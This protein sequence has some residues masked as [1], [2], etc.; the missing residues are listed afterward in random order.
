MDTKLFWQLLEDVCQLGEFIAAI[1]IKGASID[2][3]GTLRVVYDGPEYLDTVLERQ[4]CHDH[5]HITPE[6]IQAIHF[7]F[8]KNTIG[9]IEPCLELINLDGQACLTLV[10]YPYQESELKPKYKQFMAQ[11]QSCK[12]VVNGEW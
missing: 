10:Y 7:G 1:E 5:I 12:D 3:V 6:H 8:C 11:H 4:D 2:I 9:V